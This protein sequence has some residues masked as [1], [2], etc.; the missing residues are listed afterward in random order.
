MHFNSFK[1][2]TQP[3]RRRFV[4]SGLLALRWLGLL[5]GITA[6]LAANPLLAQEPQ[7]GAL[8]L[9]ETERI[10]SGKIIQRGD[11][12]DVELAANSRISIATSQVAR[13][14]GSREE[15]YQFKCDSISRIGAASQAQWSVGD[16]FQLTRWCLVNDLLP[17]AAAHYTQVAERNPNHPR[18]KQ[19][20]VELQ[21]RLLHD[22]AFRQ[23]LGL[24]PLASPA[25]I[26]VATRDSTK[27]GQAT[28]GRS[29]PAASISS[30]NA[31]GDAPSGVV[32]VSTVGTTAPIQHP[33]IAHRFTERVQPI[34][35]SRCSQAA[36]HGVQSQH[37]LKL[38][39]PYGQSN[40][41]A[42]TEN[43]ASVLNQVEAGPQ[44]MSPLV[45]YAL[46]PHG[47]QRTAAIAMSETR[48]IQELQEWIEFVR[49]PVVSAVSFGQPPN[50]TFYPSGTPP[51]GQNSVS[52]PTSSSST[53]LSPAGLNLVAPGDAKLRSVPPATP[54][55][56]GAATPVLDPFDPAEFN[57]K[58]Q[59]ARS[60]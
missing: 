58:T 10:I 14:A 2:F 52:N 3:T 54:V 59:A 9:K 30:A 51:L 41:R 20:G 40:S 49:N 8:M 18:V 19:L 50:G 12:Y 55:S 11:F 27:T 38:L 33:Q 36:C 5:A 28:A 45:R 13:L 57:R 35:I 39:E 6:F 21:Q 48:L 37:A 15:L 25:A 44:Q 26:Q 42:T 16:H 29:Q 31:S 17:Q 4:R 43:L 34:L 22:E 1:L 47:T 7:P 53:S 23:H 24:P 46:Q 56:A 60:E 32:S